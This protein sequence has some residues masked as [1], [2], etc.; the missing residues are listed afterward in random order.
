MP[1][2]ASYFTPDGIRPGRATT[3]SS[4]LTARP[5]RLRNSEVEGER[6]SVCNV[7]R[8]CDIQRFKRQSLR[9]CWMRTEEVT[10]GSRLSA[11]TRFESLVGV[12]NAIGMHRDPQE[13]F[14]ALLR[15]L[16]RVVRFDC[17]GVG[18]LG[19]KKNK[20]HRHSLEAEEE[21]PAP[22]DPQLVVEESDAW[23]GLPN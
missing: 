2:G 5:L 21:A 15:E 20:V 16:H 6:F 14:G 3:C 9:V 10:D 19:E 4:S 13:L 22:P 12:S 18:I 1:R 7:P 11:A 23:C 8:I 17:I